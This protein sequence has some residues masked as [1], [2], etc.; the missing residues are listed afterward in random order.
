MKL[1]KWSAKCHLKSVGMFE[2]Q[3]KRERREGWGER[4][5]EIGGKFKEGSRGKSENHG[6]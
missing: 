5:K 1:H 3:I 2:C 4:E 6:F